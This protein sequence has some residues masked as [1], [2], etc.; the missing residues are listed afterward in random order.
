LSLVLEI[1]LDQILP[2]A[3]A[4]LEQQGVP[5][6]AV[7][8]EPLRQ[9]AESAREE[10]KM[11]LAPRGD[12]TEVTIA[13]F[14]RIYPG[15]GLN[16]PRTPLEMIYPRADRLALFAVT[17]GQAV[18]D[19]IQ[20][21][22]RAN[23][24]PLGAALDAG[25]SLAADQ[26]AQVAQDRFASLQ[27]KPAGVLRYSPGYCGWH[28]SG[29]KALFAGLGADTAGISLTE[30]CLMHPLKS[31]S[32]VIIAGAPEVHGFV[33]DYSFC[34]ECTGKECRERIRSVADSPPQE[35]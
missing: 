26:A 2:E 32:G 35:V 25:A 33:N 20:E 4:I 31:V 12:L 29:Q 1:T 23:D 16:D 34:T 14:A 9:L 8:S 11:T 7:V 18:G 28:V 30:S 13:D 17:C 15:Q 6:G 19:R 21:L 24:Y 22:F 5:A 3:S 27:D 10:L